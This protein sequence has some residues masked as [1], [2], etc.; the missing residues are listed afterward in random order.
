[1]SG[2]VPEASAAVD[3]AVHMTA[4]PPAGCLFTGVSQASVTT[5]MHRVHQGKAGGHAWPLTLI[6]ASGD[7]N[8]LHLEHFIY[9]WYWVSPHPLQ[10]HFDSASKFAGPFTSFCCRETHVSLSCEALQKCCI[11]SDWCSL[12]TS[13]ESRCNQEDA[14]AHLGLLLH[15]QSGCSSCPCSPIGLYQTFIEHAA[16]TFMCWLDTTVQ[17]RQDM[18]ATKRRCSAMEWHTRPLRGQ[19]PLQMYGT[20]GI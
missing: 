1:M 2:S 11:T 7:L 12:D 14:R 9:V 10:V 16:Q 18:Y 6:S 5:Q 17:E 4:L 3:T 15:R 13:L 20:K 8:V 19:I